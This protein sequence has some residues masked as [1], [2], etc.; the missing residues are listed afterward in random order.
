MT[1]NN[2]NM[3]PRGPTRAPIGLREGPKM[4]LRTIFC[5][6]YS[7]KAHV[8]FLAACRAIG[9][10][11]SRRE[12]PQAFA[13][14]QLPPDPTD[15]LA[16]FPSG[17]TLPQSS[18]LDLTQDSQA[19]QT[20]HAP[21]D[22]NMVDPPRARALVRAREEVMP[23]A[24]VPVQHSALAY[25][26]VKAALQQEPTQPN[27][28]GTPVQRRP[29]TTTRFTVFTRPAA[30]AS[31]SRAQCNRRRHSRRRIARGRQHAQHSA[32]TRRKPRQRISSWWRRASGSGGRTSP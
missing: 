8:L 12:F 19:D 1:Q 24:S 11:P 18:P 29:A 3:A 14:S 10:A 6:S 21:P 30:S 9:M 23:S 5:S 17:D 32:R 25:A 15:T 31:T 4:P 28:K 20:F 13:D 7:R 16:D 22:R 2:P 27:M 26:N